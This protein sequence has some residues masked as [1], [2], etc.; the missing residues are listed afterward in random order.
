[1][2]MVAMN[3]NPKPDETPES[4]SNFWS[5]TAVYG[6]QVAHCTMCLVHTAQ[7]AKLYVLCRAVSAPC[8][9]VP[10]YDLAMLLALG[11]LLLR[12][13]TSLKSSQGQGCMP[14]LVSRINGEITN[15]LTF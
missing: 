8:K 3:Q 6:A 15:G 4:P 10:C 9:G 11:L 2:A 7:G 5:N 13:A 12:R 1:M 14:V